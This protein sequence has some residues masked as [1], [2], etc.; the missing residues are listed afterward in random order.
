MQPDHYVTDAVRQFRKLKDLAERAR[1]QV[2]DEA[3]AQAT[4]LLEAA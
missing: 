3:R 1:A 2:T 4:R